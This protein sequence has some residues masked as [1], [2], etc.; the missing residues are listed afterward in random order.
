MIEFKN[1][2][3]EQERWL[4]VVNSRDFDEDVGTSA[5]DYAALDEA[6]NHPLAISRSY[7]LHLQLLLRQDRRHSF[8]LP[9]KLISESSLTGVVLVCFDE[10]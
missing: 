9:V 10:V 1:Q 3:C 7:V 5:I 4:F 2:S 6:V 8:V